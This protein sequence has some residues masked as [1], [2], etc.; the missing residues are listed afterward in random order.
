VD[1]LHT[2]PPPPAVEPPP[3][4]PPPA[5]SQRALA[6]LLAARTGAD[7]RTCARALREGP[8]VIRTANVREAIVRE[9]D[10]MGITPGVERP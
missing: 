3:P 8:E 9:L 2:L 1:T 6:H 4:A 7:W 5:A 10:A